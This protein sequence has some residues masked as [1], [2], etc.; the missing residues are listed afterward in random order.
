MGGK[1]MRVIVNK[2]DNFEISDTKL[3]EQYKNRAN[4]NV[5]KRLIIERKYNK[6]YEKE[7]EEAF[8][9]ASLKR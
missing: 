3:V 5:I 7:L 1:M 6:C 8:R 9:N 4:Y 2:P